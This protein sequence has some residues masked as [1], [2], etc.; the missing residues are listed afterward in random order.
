M[1]FVRVCCLSWVQKSSSCSDSCQIVLL[2][3]GEMAEGGEGGGERKTKSK[4]GEMPDLPESKATDE[5][6]SRKAVEEW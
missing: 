1:C 2:A 6:K 5:R 4:T 3:S